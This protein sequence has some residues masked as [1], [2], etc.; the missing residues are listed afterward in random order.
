MQGDGPVCAAIDAG[1][2]SSIPVSAAGAAPPAA[3]CASLGHAR[4]DQTLACQK[5]SGHLLASRFT[6]R[7]APALADVVTRNL[8][9][10]TAPLQN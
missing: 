2:V 6:S 5:L 4:Q 10:S 8:P 1:C 3:P 7:S 9:S